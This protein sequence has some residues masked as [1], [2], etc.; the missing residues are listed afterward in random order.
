MTEKEKA[1]EEMQ[2]VFRWWKEFEVRKDKKGA[3]EMRKAYEELR[4]QYSQKYGGDDA[5]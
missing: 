2:K 4:Q 5:Q 3:V 1:W